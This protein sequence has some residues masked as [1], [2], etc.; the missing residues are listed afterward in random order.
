M[1]LDLVETNIQ[2]EN[3]DV[4]TAQDIGSRQAARTAV[5]DYNLTGSAVLPVTRHFPLILSGL[6]GPVTSSEIGTSGFYRHEITEGFDLP[7][8][9]LFEGKDHYEKID[10]GCMIEDLTLESRNN[11]LEA[12]VGVTGSHDREQSLRTVSPTAFDDEV[13][14]VL[15]GELLRDGTDITPEVKSFNLTV[16]NTLDDDDKIPFDKR[17][18]DKIPRPDELRASLEFTI[19]FRNQTEL[20]R[21]WGDQNADHPQNQKTRESLTL[22]FKPV[23]DEREFSIILP[24]NIMVSHAA[25]LDARTEVTQQV[26]YR[27]LYDRNTENGLEF[28]FVNDHDGS[29]Y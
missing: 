26:T 24:D 17:W 11:F 6:L 7:S 2:G 16:E 10:L 15:G 12:T 25:P 9:T 1:F 18:K 19:K 8:F 14:T 3:N 5:T 22:S 21:F 27:G 29:I 20:L 4:D 28:E 13:F 23:P